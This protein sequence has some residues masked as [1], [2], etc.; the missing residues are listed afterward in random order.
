[1]LLLTGKFCFSVPAE[2]FNKPLFMHIPHVNCQVRVVLRQSQLVSYFSTMDVESCLARVG[3]DVLS[4]QTDHIQSADVD[5]LVS[6]ALLLKN[7]N[8][9]FIYLVDTINIL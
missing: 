8:E 1:M 3:L 5:F 4:F 9:L 7:H 6:H 2:K